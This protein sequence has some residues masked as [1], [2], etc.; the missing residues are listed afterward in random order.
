MFSADSRTQRPSLCII[1]Y[2]EKFTAIIKKTN[3]SVHS[4]DAQCYQNLIS[5]GRYMFF[6]LFF[7]LESTTSAA[8]ANISNRY[9]LSHFLYFGKGLTDTGLTSTIDLIKFLFNF[10]TFNLSLKLYQDG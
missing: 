6:F 10:F 4:R 2:L 3:I 5:I 9:L 1:E 8:T 7:F